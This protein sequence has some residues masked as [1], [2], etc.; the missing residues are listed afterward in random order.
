MK[1]RFSIL[2]FFLISILYFAQSIS[3]KIIGENGETISYVEIIVK[4]DSIKK[5]TISDEKGSF[6]L[7]VPERGNYILE[8]LDN[9]IKVFTNNFYINGDTIESIRLTK[10][11]DTVIQEVVVNKKVVQQ[12]GDKTYFN[13]EN[14]ILSK[15]NNGL[16]ILQKSPKLSIN[17]EGVVLLKNKAAT[18]LVNGRKINLS[19]NDLNNYLFGLS[20]EDIKRI[21]IQDVGSVDQDASNIGGVINIILKNNPKGF[22]LI[23]KMSYAFRKEKAT[24]YSSGLNLNYGNEKWNLYSDVSYTENKNYGKSTGIFNY[25]NGQKNINNGDSKLSNN[26]LGL[27]LGSIFYPNDN[28]TFGI[29]AYYNKNNRIFEGNHNLDI[30]NGNDQTI[31]SKNISSSRTPSNLWYITTNYALKLDGLGSNLKFIGDVGRNNTEP[32]NDVYSEYLLN[33]SM[34]SHYLY[35]TNS[36]SDYYTGQLD[37][38]QKI[39]KEWELNVGGKFGSVK[40]YNLLKVDYFNNDKWDEDLNQK[41]DFNNREN[42][43]AGYISISKIFGKHFIKTGIRVE[44]TNIKG[45]NNLNNEELKQNYT[46]L[47]PSL[48]YKYDLKNENS[49]SFSYKRSITRPSF[50]DLNPFV[51]KQ[52]DFL[53]EIGN[54]S[55]QPLYVDQLEFGYNMKKHSF[56]IYG[57]KM[58]N[59]IQGVYFTNKD[60]INFFQPQNFRKYYEIGIDHSFNGNITKWLNANISSGIYYN[61]FHAND[62]INN[63]GASFYNNTY[64]QMKLSKTFLLELS[65]NY[66]H[67]Y[68]YRNVTGA[69]RYRMDISIRK[70]LMGRNLLV[71]FKVMDLFNTERDKNISHYKD[72]NFDFYQKWQTRGFLISVQ[73]ILDNKNKI[74]TGSVKSDNDSRGRL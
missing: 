15:G 35:T 6:S 31:S 14:S 37:W 71:L 9:G 25:N 3:G 26:N 73:Y 38:T 33:S 17:S 5:A 55:L 52:N 72:F 68:Q 36:V 2:F 66:Y 74:K 13:V 46:K 56:S 16:E 54:P 32:F 69:N 58:I 29:E 27:R 62:G 30:Y 23:N 48:Y 57:N 65:S 49:L 53:Y 28:N 70:T 8:I 12:L 10:Y 22:R 41:Q 67:Q 50:R 44:N 7:K 42:I 64:L 47:F 60:L 45:Y 63:K 59:T 18:I 4:R 24:Q 51:I 61:S 39:K 20:S 40:R 1:I 34:N 11:N 21:E 19:G 43:L